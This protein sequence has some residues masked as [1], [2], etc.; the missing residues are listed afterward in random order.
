MSKRKT[1]QA[2]A[3]VDEQRP[4]TYREER[5]ID[6]YLKNGGNA[7]AAYR[8]ANPGVTVLTSHTEG[9]KLL[10]KP[11]I[12]VALEAER[13]RLRSFARVTREDVIRMLVTI[14]TTTPDEVARALRSP[15][16]QDSYVGLGDKRYALTVQKTPD[17]YFA[18]TPTV[19]ERRAALNDL[20]EKLG[21]GKD[22]GEGDRQS[23]LERFAQLG[24]RL[25]RSGDGGKQTGGEGST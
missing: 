24:A 8:E 2:S 19:S 15:S 10:R 21:L 16:Q 17:G 9:S 5:F 23:F 20:W 1:D 6:Y 22:A 7:S 14:A 4:L 12:Q 18:S 3:D 25:G 13:E 11:C